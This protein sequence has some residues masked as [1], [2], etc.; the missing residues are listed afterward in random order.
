MGGDPREYGTGAIVGT[1]YAPLVL[2][3]NVI[4]EIRTTDD[5]ESTG[6][7]DIITGALG[8]DI[9]IGGV[10]G[11]ATGKDTIE[12]NAH[13][14]VIVGDNAQLLYN[15]DGLLPTTFAEHSSMTS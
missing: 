8:D 5:V 4:A 2:T 13:N 14:D 12:G 9:L 15:V 10:N 11:D 1:A 6:G 7:A 3:N